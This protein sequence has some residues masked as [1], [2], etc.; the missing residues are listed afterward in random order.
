M[1][2]LSSG[3]GSQGL[4]NNECHP[5]N[6]MAYQRCFQYSILLKVD[7]SQNQQPGNCESNQKY[8]TD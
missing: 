6:E 8:F 2:T 1:Q 4:H 7:S 3:T 5:H